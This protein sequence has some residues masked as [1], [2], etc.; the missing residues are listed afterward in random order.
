MPSSA[1]RWP[2]L[3]GPATAANEYEEAP[4]DANQANKPDRAASEAFHII[5]ND[6]TAFRSVDNRADFETLDT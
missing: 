1:A 4:H 5:P 3:T 2:Y 6:E